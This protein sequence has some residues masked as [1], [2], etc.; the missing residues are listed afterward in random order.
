[1]VTLPAV[2]SNAADR[3]EAPERLSSWVARSFFSAR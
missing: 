1:M 2:T 3:L